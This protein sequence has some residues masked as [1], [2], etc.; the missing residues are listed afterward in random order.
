[1]PSSTKDFPP[2]RD[3]GVN[4]VVGS[5]R[6]RRE[7]G[8]PRPALRTTANRVGMWGGVIGGMQRQELPLAVVEQFH[9]LRRC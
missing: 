7:N 6:S 3:G 1:M 2:P 8:L 4:A 9:R 5:E